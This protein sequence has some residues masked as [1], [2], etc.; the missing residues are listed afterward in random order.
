MA[1]PQFPDVPDTPGVPPVLRDGATDNGETQLT[2]N[3]STLSGDAAFVW[4]IFSQSGAR[5]LEPTS[6]VS[7]EFNNENRLLDYPVAPDGFETYNKVNSPFETR[8]VMTKDGPLGERQQFLA[9]VDRMVRGMDVVDVVTP[10]K[11]YL[12]VNLYRTGLSRSATSG[13]GMVVVEVGLRE[14]R[15]TATAQFTQ[16]D[17]STTTGTDQTGPATP[18]PPL[19]SGT[20]QSPSAVRPRSNGSTQVRDPLNPLGK[21]KAEINALET[22]R[23]KNLGLNVQY[24]PSPPDKF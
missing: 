5:I 3:K 15:E 14:I 9:D 11:T 22:Q 20:T 19:T 24:G 17:A 12:G 6:I 4:G 7:F 8:L 1:D 13:A 16:T 2:A 18:N 21:S 10:E 23:L